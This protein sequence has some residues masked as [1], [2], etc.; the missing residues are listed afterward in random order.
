MTRIKRPAVPAGGVL[1]GA[2]ASAG[3]GAGGQYGQPGQLYHGLQKMDPK[4]L[5]RRGPQRRTWKNISSDL[6]GYTT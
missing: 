6:S 2:D 5:D 1:H 4:R 3:L